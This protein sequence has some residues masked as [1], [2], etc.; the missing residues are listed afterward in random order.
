[1]R[2]TE[3][4]IDR[5]NLV[6]THWNVLNNENRVFTALAIR[7]AA[8]DVACLQEVD[9]LRTLKKFHHGYLRK[10]GELNYRHRHLVDGNDP[11]GI[12]VAVMSRFKIDYATSY[13]DVTFADMGIDPP[14]GG[15]SANRPVFRRDC[16]EVGIKRDNMILPI[17]VCHFKSMSGDRDETRDKRFAEATTVR[18]IVE[19]RFADQ[20]NPDWLIVGDLNDYTEDEQGNPDTHHGLGPLFEDNFAVDLIKRIANPGDRWTHYWVGGRQYRQIDYILASTSLAEK[21][22]SAPTQSESSQWKPDSEYKT[23]GCSSAR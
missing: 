15:E 6:R 2:Y 21:N 9:T 16:L 22:P 12:D 23:T 11:R 1:M 7:D 20:A 19:E 14:P 4:E 10:Y 3:T 8:P 17:F 13:Q 18:R 5:A